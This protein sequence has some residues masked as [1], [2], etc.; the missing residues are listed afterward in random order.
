MIAVPILQTRKQIPEWLDKDPELVKMQPERILTHLF[1]KR[2]FQCLKQ[3]PGIKTHFYAPGMYPSLL[4]APLPLLW[5]NTSQWPGKGHTGAA[6]FPWH[7]DPPLMT[8]KSLLAMLPR[9]PM[10]SQIPAGM[11]TTQ[12]PVSQEAKRK[13]ISLG[14]LALW[15]NPCNGKK[16]RRK[17]R[18]HNNKTAPKPSNLTSNSAWVCWGQVLGCQHSRRKGEIV[19]GFI[20]LTVMVIFF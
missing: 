19:W 6:K 2:S 10:P 13:G 7:S 3:G 15:F 20:C 17:E 5:G 1:R 18:K 11:C 9:G 8:P 16:R 12:P 4:S 14:A